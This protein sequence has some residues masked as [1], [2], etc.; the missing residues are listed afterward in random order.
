MPFLQRNLVDA[1]DRQRLE[2]RPIDLVGDPSIQDALHSAS[3]P[4]A[5]LALTSSERAVDE[6]TQHLLFEGPLVAVAR[7]V[8]HESVWLV[9]GR[10]G[11]KWH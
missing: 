6:L 3:T 2:R 11:Q 5:C 7:G 8:Y 10:S 4:M 1:N 9:V